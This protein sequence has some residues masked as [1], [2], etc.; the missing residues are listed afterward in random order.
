MIT[1][2]YTGE[3]IRTKLNEEWSYRSLI[4]KKIGGV[5]MTKGGMYRIFTNDFY[6]GIIH[7]NGESKVGIHELMITLAEFEK[8]QYILERKTQPKQQTHDYAYNGVVTCG[9]CG[10]FITA[11]TKQKYKKDGSLSKI[12]TLY[13]CSNSRKKD[14]TCSQ[15][16]FT[17]VDII[18]KEIKETIDSIKID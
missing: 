4:R 1:G 8:V 6:A 16:T 9:E 12:Y 14:H 15:K 13:Y 5:K 17:N 3:E 2:K 18:E 11:T 7:S 10:G